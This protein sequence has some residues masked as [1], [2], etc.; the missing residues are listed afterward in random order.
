V[1]EEGL[2]A[3][4]GVHVGDRVFIPV[5]EIV[6]NIHQQGAWIQ[7]TPVAVIVLDGKEEY[8]L[9]LTKEITLKELKAKLP[10]VDVEIQK[11]SSE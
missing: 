5:A 8:L 11:W 10:H 7:V 2:V 6:K 1:T 4:S 9:P 3:G